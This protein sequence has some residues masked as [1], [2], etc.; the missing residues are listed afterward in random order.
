MRRK[1]AH[2]SS[3]KTKTTSQKTSAL[4]ILLKLS[5]GEIIALV[6]LAKQEHAQASVVDYKSL[7][8]AE[9]LHAAIIDHTPVEKSS[10]PVSET[11]TRDTSPVTEY[12]NEPELGPEGWGFIIMLIDI[13]N[14][15]IDPRPAKHFTQQTAVSRMRALKH[16][17]VSTHKINKFFLT[18]DVLIFFALLARVTIIIIK[19]LFTEKILLYSVKSLFALL[20][21]MV[22]ILNA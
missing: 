4:N 1:K 20:K 2:S 6:T 14:K 10:S 3:S 5:P 22:L 8:D 12:Q 17:K 19:L 18:V 9:L 16:S 21:S 7:T 13:L 15:F 11:N